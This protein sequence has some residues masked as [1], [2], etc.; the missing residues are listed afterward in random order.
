MKFGGDMDF[1]LEPNIA[2]LVLLAGVLLGF[3]ALVSPGT[4]LFEVGALFCIALAG[5]AVFKLSFNGWALVLLLLSIVPF[6]YAI[7]KPK[8]EWFLGLAILLIVVGSVFVF[9]GSEDRASVNPLVAITASTLVAGFL[10]IAVRGSIEA[11]NRR[12]VHDLEALLGKSGEART[13]I[14]DDGSV[15]VGAE[16]WSARSDKEIPAGSPVRVLRREGF[17]L[18]VEKK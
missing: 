6:V 8:R 17:I 7:Q 3:M 16:L 1:L 9:P 15:Q 13:K 12:P 5:Y 10:W 18:V 14:K 11:G 4:G 2:Y